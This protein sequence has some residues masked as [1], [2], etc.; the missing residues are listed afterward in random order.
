MTLTRCL[1]V[2]N[3]DNDD[4]NYD[5]YDDR[6]DGDDHDL[7]MIII[8]Q[9]TYFQHP[10]GW[11]KKGFPGPQGPYYCGVGANKVMFPLPS[12]PIS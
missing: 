8:I 11:P 3:N 2:S 6:N 9:L 12:L 4:R 10:Y 1:P 7:E 5:K